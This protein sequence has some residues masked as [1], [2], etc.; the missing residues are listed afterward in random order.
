[1][2]SVC[3]AY[4]GSAIEPNR[5][6]PAWAMTSKTGPRG[7][8]LSTDS[9]RTARCAQPGAC[10]KHKPWHDSRQLIDGQTNQGFGLT[11]QGVTWHGV[12][13][14]TRLRDGQHECV[15]VAPPCSS[16]QPPDTVQG[17][18]SH[19]GGRAT[20]MRS[21]PMRSMAPEPN[22]GEGIGS[23]GQGVALSSGKSPGPVHGE[24]GGVTWLGT[25]CGVGTEARH[26]GGGLPN[27]DKRHWHRQDG[28]GGASFYSHARRGAMRARR[29]K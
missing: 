24:E 25:D 15:H 11:L 12:V 10:S 19:Q 29:G 20:E 4:R 17:T 9:A 16:V 13:Q 6:G 22:G 1:M 26:G 3:S 28:M 14:S 7:L 5:P 18:S 27:T 2:N 21:S 8:A 23:L